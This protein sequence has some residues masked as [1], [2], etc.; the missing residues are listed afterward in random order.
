MDAKDDNDP[1][2]FSRYLSLI[3]TEWPPELGNP[4]DDEIVAEMKKQYDK[5]RDRIR[6]WEEGGAT[7]AWYRY[8]KWPRDAESTDEIH[9]LD[10]AVDEEH[11]GK[12]L[13]TAL[14][15]DLLRICKEEGVRMIYS[16][17]ALSNPASIALHRKAGF[18]EKF[19]REDSIVWEKSVE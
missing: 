2:D 16:M 6:C 11:R 15:G 9:L 5:R 13:G 7:I 4:S 10:I 12:G 1:G 14:L 8:T 3:R 17:T 18:A 19:R